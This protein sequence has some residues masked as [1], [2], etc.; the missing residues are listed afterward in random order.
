MITVLYTVTILHFVLAAF[1]IFK[2]KKNPVNITFSLFLVGGALW[3][4]T[5]ALFQEALTEQEMF[6]W[7]AASYSAAT[8]MLF[9]LALFSKL[10]IAGSLGKKTAIALALTG[11]ISFIVVYIPDFVL[12]GVNFEGKAIIGGPALPLLFATYIALMFFTLITLYR[13][14]ILATARRKMQLKLVFYGILVVVLIGNTTNLILPSLNVYSLVAFGPSFSL[15]FLSLVAVAILKYQLLD[16]RFLLGRVIYYT[17]LAALVYIAFYFFVNFYELTFGSTTSIPT[18][19]VGVPIAYA[20][21]LAFSAFDSIVKNYTDTQ[22]I[23]PGYNPLETIDQL[24]RATNQMLDLQDIAEISLATIAK[25][26]RPSI[27]GL[28]IDTKGSAWKTFSHKT[29]LDLNSKDYSFIASLFKVDEFKPILLDLLDIDITN[30]PNL[31]NQAI[32]KIMHRDN[33]H[34]IVPIKDNENIIGL[35]ALGAK[36]GNSPYNMQDIRLLEG[37]S[38]NLGLAI[39]RSLLYREIQQFNK[40]L[41]RKVEQATSELKE[42]NSNLEVALAK[43]EEIRRQERD[44]IDVMGHELRTPISIVRN[45]LMVL[46][47]KFKKNAGEIPK[48]MLGKY[49]EMAIESVK[50]ELILIETFLS[51]TKVEGN[52]IQLRLQKIDLNDVVNDSLEALGRDA[53]T[54]G[55]NIIHKPSKEPIYAYADRVRTQEIM[56]NFVSNAIKYT[57]R[58]SIT[59]DVKADKKWVTATVKDTGVG[60]SRQDLEKLGKKF[61]RAQPHY[62]AT[63]GA[64]PSGTGLGLYVTFELIDIMNG[65]RI[66]TSELGK[67]STFGFA[68]PI[69]DGQEEKQIDQTFMTDPSLASET[70]DNYAGKPINRAL[71]RFMNREEI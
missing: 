3:S 22:L 65:K 47:G 46:D 45:A 62:S 60:I 66:I 31:T 17:L 63:D 16:I 38:G 71:N 24:T 27:A 44:M 33:I 5:N 32:L 42:K 12:K 39:N 21:V 6:G 61:F 59:I 49:L 18:L 8:V 53:K 2:D 14:M 7:A 29:E 4:L 15:V 28:V 50:R 26:I 19:I 54:K 13:G 9:F 48:E 52:R 51:A 43:I 10:M 35:L 30:S 55:L 64:R 69:F 70:V 68:L 40:D 20:F 11:L 36:D 37:I 41:Q 57:P 58:G 34:A 1:V 67:G 25:T 56:D 23:N